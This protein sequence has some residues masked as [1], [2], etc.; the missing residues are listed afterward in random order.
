MKHDWIMLTPRSGP[1]VT[2]GNPRAAVR[3]ETGW[4]L[5][6]TRCEETLDVPYDVLDSE[7]IESFI[8]KQKR[9]KDCKGKQK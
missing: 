3:H 1:L 6:C 7:N 8:V 9:R 2:V 4:G 5:R